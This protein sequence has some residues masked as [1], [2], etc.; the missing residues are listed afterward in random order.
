MADVIVLG[1]GAAGLSAAHFACKAGLQVE[2]FEASPHP[3][4]RMQTTREKGFTVEH[5]P[6]GWLDGD[7]VLE[8]ISIAHYRDFTWKRN[9]LLEHGILD[10]EKNHLVKMGKEKKLPDHKKYRKQLQLLIN[11][12]MRPKSS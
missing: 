7:E 5:G 8:E 1:A 9:Q 6:L 4:G 12:P 10:Q 2:I 11:P 3:G